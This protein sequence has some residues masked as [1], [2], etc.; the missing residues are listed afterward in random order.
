MPYEVKK[1]GAH[2]IVRNKATGHVFAKHTTVMK[3]I[4]QVRLLHM[5]EASGQYSR[6]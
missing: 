4:K 1:V 3:A 6:L 5:K 2:Y